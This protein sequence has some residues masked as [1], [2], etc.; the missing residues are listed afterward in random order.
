MRFP[1]LA[2]APLSLLLAASSSTAPQ[3]LTPGSTPPPLR[4]AV[5][6]TGHFRSIALTW[7]SVA[8]FLLKPWVRGCYDPPLPPSPPSLVDV[9]GV[10]LVNEDDVTNATRSDTGKT[11]TD[12]DV[13]S[14]NRNVRSAGASP[15]EVL[16]KGS[17]PPVEDTMR[18]IRYPEISR[19]L[20]QIALKQYADIERYGMP[21]M[22]VSS[23][24]SLRSD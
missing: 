18:Y 23:A 7:P 22:V 12:F 17:D 13:A 20:M 15:I 5:C 21:V 16:V 6:V 9:F 4:V 11:S 3:P 19:A 1:P 2:F 24:S 14:F 10:I 8:E